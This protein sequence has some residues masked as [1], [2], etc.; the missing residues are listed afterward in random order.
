M[1]A[2]F[3]RV[4]E[5][6]LVLCA[7]SARPFVRAE[8]W[9][10]GWKALLGVLMAEP[11]LEDLHC[12]ALRISLMLICLTLLVLCAFLAKTLL[13]LLHGGKQAKPQLFSCCLFAC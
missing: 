10:L 11:A 7:L 5:G 4:W 13:E 3:T 2:L 1:K 8:F 9:H 6:R 12:P